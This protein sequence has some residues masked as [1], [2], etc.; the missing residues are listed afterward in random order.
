MQN[1][2]SLAAELT[3]SDSRTHKVW[4]QN[5]QS[6]SRTY[7]HNAEHTEVSPQI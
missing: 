6:D 2:Q 4:Q 3:K 5:S 1:S 7:S